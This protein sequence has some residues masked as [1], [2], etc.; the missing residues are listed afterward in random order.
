MTGLSYSVNWKG[1]EEGKGD[2]YFKVVIFLEVLQK[3]TENV[4]HGKW[5]SGLDLYQV[6]LES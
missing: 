2:A 4:S 5:C 6:T 3:S 1:W